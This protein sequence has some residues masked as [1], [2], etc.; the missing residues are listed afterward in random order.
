MNKLDDLPSSQAQAKS[1]GATQYYTGKPCKNGHISPRK[2][3]SGNCIECL[4]TVHKKA[5]AAYARTRCSKKRAA[6]A[7]EENRASIRASRNQGQPWTAADVEKVTAR[8]DGG[9]YLYTERELSASLGRSM[10]SISRA[11]HRYC[12]KQDAEKGQYE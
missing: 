7:K 6:K 4:R 1:V 5:A 12:E 3:A 10:R 8:G 2:A 11:R 9:E